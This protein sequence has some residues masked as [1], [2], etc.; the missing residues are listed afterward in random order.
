MRWC[1]WLNINY[2]TAVYKTAA[3]LKTIDFIN[4]KD[5]D[6]VG[7]ADNKDKGMGMDTHSHNHT[8]ESVMHLQPDH[9]RSLNQNRQSLV[10][11]NLV[12]P[13]VFFH[14]HSQGKFLDHFRM[15]EQ[16]LPFETHYS[17]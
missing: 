5:T 7:M 1:L 3:T 2:K 15:L 9:L 11:Q 8:L 6:T 13:M 14:N 4:N 16:V 10:D 12:S 17:R